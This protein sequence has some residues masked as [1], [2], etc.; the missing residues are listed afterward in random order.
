MVSHASYSLEEWIQTKTLSMSLLS[1]KK[2]NKQKKPSNLKA[3]LPCG[4]SEKQS[5]L[6]ILELNMLLKFI[7]NMKNTINQAACFPLLSFPSHSLLSVLSG[8]P[9]VSGNC[10]L[11]SLFTGLVSIPYWQTNPSIETAKPFRAI[12]NLL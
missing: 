2:P 4:H 10:F 7:I 8:A 9:C 12:S 1:F 6:N 3:F 11:C 5:R